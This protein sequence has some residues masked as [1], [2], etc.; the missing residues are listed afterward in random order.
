MRDQNLSR[1]T[2]QPQ[3]PAAMLRERRMQRVQIQSTNGNPIRIGRSV[4]WLSRAVIAEFGSLWTPGGRLVHLTDKTGRNI[5]HDESWFRQHCDVFEPSPKLPDVAIYD[6]R[7]KLLM[8]ITTVVKPCLIDSEQHDT[9]QRMLQNCRVRPLFVFAFR[10]RKDMTSLLDRFY[11]PS[12]AWAAEE[13][14]HLIHFNGER[15][16]MPHDH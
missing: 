14:E 12:I 9:L 13:P 11:W 5:Y 16:L 8:L 2:K 7:K 10:S 1:E 15:F 4:S 3:Q 6:R